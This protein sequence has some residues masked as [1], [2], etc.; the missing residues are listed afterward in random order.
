MNDD[1]LI[2]LEELESEVKELKEMNKKLLEAVENLKEKGVYRKNRKSAITEEIARDYV[3][4]DCHIT[5]A[6]TEK[7]GMSYPA[8]K[9]R[10]IKA[11][12]ITK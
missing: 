10:L 12:M 8:I 5:S 1:Y 4:A 3:A 9:N 11:G 7:Y 6:M 2:K